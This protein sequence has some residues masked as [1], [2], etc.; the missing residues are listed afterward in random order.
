MLRPEAGHGEQEV[1]TGTNYVDWNFLPELPEEFQDTMRLHEGKRSTEACH[2]AIERHF[3]TETAWPGFEKLFDVLYM[4]ATVSPLLAG[5]LVLRNCN[6]RT[7]KIQRDSMKG[8]VQQKHDHVKRRNERERKRVE[9]VNNGFAQLRDRVVTT[10]SLQRIAQG[11]KLSK[12]ETLREASKYIAELSRL[13]GQ[14]SSQPS[15]QG[16]TP[17]DFSENTLNAF[18]SFGYSFS[19]ASYQPMSAIVSPLSSN[20]SHRSDNSFE[21]QKYFPHTMYH[22]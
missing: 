19:P 11:K 3:S 7:A 14:C 22:S 20:S 6:V 10:T 5:A 8:N 1:L 18:D 15:S 9:Q 21:E 13:L 16:S 4:D 2:N 12:V 17:T